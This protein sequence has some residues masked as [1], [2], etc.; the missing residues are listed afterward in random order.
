MLGACVLRVG[1]SLPMESG[2]NWK[3]TSHLR[4]LPGTEGTALKSTTGW[5]NNGNGTDDFG[6][7]ALPGGYRY[8]SNGYFY[9]AGL[10]ATGGV[11][12]RSGGDAWYRYLELLLVQASSGATYNPR[13]GFS[14][15]CLRD[16]EILEVHGCTDPAYTEYDATWPPADDGSCSPQLVVFGCTDPAYTSSTTPRPTRTTAVAKTC[17]GVL[18]RPT[19]NS[20]RQLLR[21]MAAAPQL[22]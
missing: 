4:D 19:S 16:A 11:R 2:R 20:I 12:P 14:V 13:Y 3:T 10:T 17:W 15:R 6:F 9:N 7:S 22:W 8:S 18:I 1:T 21:T 5:S